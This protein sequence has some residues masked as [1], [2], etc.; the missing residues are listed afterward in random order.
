MSLFTIISD[1]TDSNLMK[2]NPSKSSYMLFTRSQE[3]FAT[4]LALNSQL[5]KVSRT[6]A[7]TGLLNR[8][9]FDEM[10]KD[11][12]MYHKRHK[13]AFTLAFIDI[14]HFKNIN[15]VPKGLEFICQIC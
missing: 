14:D 15:D 8:G 11:A 1:W 10:A 4:R 6:D 12:Y 13:Q 2:L 3:Q 5:L 9:A 7:L